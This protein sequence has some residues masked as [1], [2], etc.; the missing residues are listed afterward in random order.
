VSGNPNNF[1]PRGTVDSAFWPGK[2]VF[3][4]GHTGFKGSW[5]C[6]L[7][8]HL[9]AS[10]V[11]YSLP[12]DRPSLFEQAR[13]AESVSSIEGDVRSLDAFRTALAAHK[14]EIVIHMA[15]QSLVR[16]S[17]ADPVET[18]ATNVMGTV[19]L[20]AALRAVPSVRAVLVV[21]SDKCYENREWV[22][23]YR[24]TDAM[25]GFDPYSS[26]KGCA[27]LVTAAFRRSFLGSDRLGLATARAGNVIGG[28]DWSPDRLVP[29]AIRAFRSG[30]TLQVRQP[31][32]VRPWQYVLEPLTGYLILIQ[33]LWVDA[34]GFS[35]AWNFGP[36][37]DDNQPVEALVEQMVELWG[38]T[39]NW[40]SA[41]EAQL[42]EAQLLR[43]DCSKARSLLRWTPS[44][45]LADAVRWTVAW[46]LAM[47]GQSDMRAFSIRQIEDYLRLP[48]ESAMQRRSSGATVP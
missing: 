33:K 9:G 48:R 4:T 23:G 32:A 16:R 31:R 12:A 26:S 25:G 34:E 42:H 13:I 7:L 47:D 27:E 43:L 2:R 20:L 39:A 5:V 37:D 15:A 11:G 35:E 22:W 17:Y 38:R 30:T 40:S 45:A 28:G 41:E 24:E 21:T 19:N 46:Y 6:L 44:L 1:A 36:G 10:V 29:D 18:Y 8:R 14:P 3:V